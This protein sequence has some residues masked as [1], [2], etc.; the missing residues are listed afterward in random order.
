M[1][2]NNLC[3]VVFKPVT[4]G[5]PCYVNPN[6]FVFTCEN[7]SGLNDMREAA[8]FRTQGFEERLIAI[9]D[10][11][12]SGGRINAQLELLCELLWSS[13]FEGAKDA[14]KGLE[15]MLRKVFEAGIEVGR[16]GPST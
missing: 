3:L 8:W 11:E 9:I 5:V 16:K 13:G 2:M 7:R 14:G 4:Q 1:H 10:I 15:W 12:D 6:R